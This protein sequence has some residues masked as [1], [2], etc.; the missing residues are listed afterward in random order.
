MEAAEYEAAWARG[1]ALPLERV[2]AEALQ[3]AP[4]G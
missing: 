3:E 4:D 2:I 1:Q